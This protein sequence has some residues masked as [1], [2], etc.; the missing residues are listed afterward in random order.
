MVELESWDIVFLDVVVGG[1][2][3]AEELGASIGLELGIIYA[4]MLRND[5][6]LEETLFD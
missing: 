2:G 1:G 6:I 3:V 4:H 5:D